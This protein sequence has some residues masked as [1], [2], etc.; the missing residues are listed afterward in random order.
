[1]LEHVARDPASRAPDH[2]ATEHCASANDRS[3]RGKFGRS[4]LGNVASRKTL[5]SDFMADPGDLPW[6]FPPWRA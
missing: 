3:L 1:V 4:A 5:R 2:P 6:R